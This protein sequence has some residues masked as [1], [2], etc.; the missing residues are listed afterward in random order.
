[1]HASSTMLAQKTRR[2]RRFSLFRGNPE[3]ARLMRARNSQNFTA[4]ALGDRAQGRSGALVEDATE[5]PNCGITG[6]A[7]RFRRGVLPIRRSRDGL[8]GEPRIVRSVGPLADRR[9]EPCLRG[10]TIFGGRPVICCTWPS[11]HV[12]AVT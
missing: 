7:A 10:R 1:R 6:S 8:A 2:R 4:A 11:W 5:D 12:R 9:G 3:F